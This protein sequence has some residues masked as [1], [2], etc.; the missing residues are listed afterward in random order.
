MC[1]LFFA[2]KEHPKYPVIICAN[3]DEVHQRPTQMMHWWPE[4][5]QQASILAGKDLQAGGTWLGLNKQGRFSALTNFREPQL[6]DKNKQSRGDLVTQALAK[7]DQEI[8]KQLV[9]TAHQYNGFNLVFGKLD[10][11]TYFNSTSKKQQTLTT[12][13]HS[14]CNGDLDDIW[15]KMA[16]GQEQLATAIQE[17]ASQLLNIDNLFTLM[18]NNQQAE[19]EKLPKTGVPLDW[20]QRL[21]SIFIVSPE[22]GTRTTNIITQDNQGNIS[23]YDRSYDAQGKCVKEQQFSI[24]AT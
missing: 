7:Q 18:K 4:T 2:I 13:F 9:N 14:L 3:R 15:P 21:S 12:G 17:S 23:V 10:N 8:N 11:L 6:F 5:K 24:P 16:L 22:Y 19:I 20:E 1:I